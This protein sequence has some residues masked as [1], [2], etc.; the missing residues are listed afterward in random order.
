MTI[1]NSHLLG[2]D[3]AHAARRRDHPNERKSVVRASLVQGLAP[4]LDRASGQSHASGRAPPR[5]GK[6]E[7]N[8]PPTSAPRA[9]ET[10]GALGSDAGA[11]GGKLT[12]DWMDGYMAKKNRTS[13][14]I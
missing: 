4:D 13:V 12:V 6:M 8:G 2:S 14:T 5:P 1:L 11:G 9:A 3:L 7:T 10:E